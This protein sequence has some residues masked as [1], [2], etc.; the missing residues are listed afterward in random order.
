M[1]PASLRSAVLLALVTF[2][3]A[4][5]VGAQYD[6]GVGRRSPRVVLGGGV[7]AAQ[8]VG[9]FKSYV[10][11]GYGGGGHLLLRADG[12]GVLSMRVDAGYLVYGH[13]RERVRL[14]DIG[15]VEF[16]VT[17]TNNI[18][19]Y[20]AGPQLMM[21]AGPIRPYAHAFV[22]GAYFFTQSSV[23]GSDNETDFASTRNFSDNVP[24]YGYGGGV[25]I[26]FAVRNT[27]VG[28]DAG[29]RFMR[30]GHTR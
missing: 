7:L 5:P 8:P 17:T 28:L 20:S 16:D 3:A 24:S 4:E 1:R 13:E 30:N 10:N 26:P 9:E 23:G 15:R 21:P 22:G 6:L 2:A 12:R 19:T 25:F 11:S 29:A 14:P 27:P 18:V